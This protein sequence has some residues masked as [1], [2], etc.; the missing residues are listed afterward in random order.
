MCVCVRAC[1]CVTK[2]E[3]VHQSRAPR[4]VST[5]AQTELGG[6]EGTV[7]KG[8]ERRESESAGVIIVKS[9]FWW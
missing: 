2:P 7:E 8:G 4:L 9:K 3:G 6:L 5:S 1:V